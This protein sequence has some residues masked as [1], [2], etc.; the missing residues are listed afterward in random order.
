MKVKKRIAEIQERICNDELFNSI[1]NAYYD[2]AKGDE[3]L[4][5][6]EAEY[7]TARS[8]LSDILNE[9]QSTSLAEAESLCLEGEKWLMRFAY[10]RGVYVGF[11]QYFTPEK[12]NHVFEIQIMNKVMTLPGMKS[13]PSYYECRSKILELFEKARDGLCEEYTDH[14]TNIEAAW[15]NRDLGVSRHAFYTGYRYAL[16]VV[17]QVAPLGET[18]SIIDKILTTEHGLCFTRTV[19]ERERE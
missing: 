7:L 10:V 11:Q 18:Y 15:S 13:Y 5:D 3:G 1:L 14:V 9:T 16:S 6:Y 8:A 19:E 4:S 17:G 12:A 2:E